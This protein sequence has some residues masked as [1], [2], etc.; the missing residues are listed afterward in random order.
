MLVG[1]NGKD[2][3]MNMGTKDL[4]KRSREETKD[5]FSAIDLFSG[6]GG[7]S[8][9]FSQAGIHTQ[10]AVDNW[11][12]SLSTF[13]ANHTESKAIE[14]DLG[15]RNMAPLM[16]QITKADIVFGGPPCQGFSISGKR[17][18]NDPRNKLYKGFLRVVAEV[19][20]RLFLM[21][22]VPNLVSMDKGRLMYE[23]ES[24]FQQLGYF[25][26]RKVLLASDYGVPQNRRRLILVGTLSD[27]PFEMPLG[28][29][30]TD[31]TRVNCMDAL[32]D[33]P[34]ESLDDGS[35]Y[36]IEPQSAFQKVMRQG[37]KGIFNH[38][39]TQHS[40]QTKHIIGLVPDG[41]NYKNLPQ[42][43]RNT[44]NVNIAWT[45][46]A[47]NKPSFTID[48][49]HRHHFHY[50]YDRVPTVR[51][52]ARLQSFPDKFIF[53][54]SKTSQ[55]KQVGNAVPPLLARAI[56]VSIV[57]HLEGRGGNLRDAVSHS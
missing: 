1:T 35:G 24:D 56:G 15:S 4:G 25:L 37:S 2:G 48:T 40:D 13:E 3:T 7:L 53:R 34:E 21:E 23:I 19:R 38:V 20:P 41:G 42:A 9:G 27:I 18:P 5:K 29:T 14:F 36:P 32:S 55:Y 10:I 44:R 30:I 11:S 12:E 46:Y 54:G 8:Y 43:Y 33:L 45:R 57:H 50:E 16:N 6:C 49:G 31:D 22:N 52:S 28:N 51:E 47:S 17:N 26:T 39:I